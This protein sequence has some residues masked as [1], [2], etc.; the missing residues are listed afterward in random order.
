[1]SAEAPPPFRYRAPSKVHYMDEP[2]Q[3]KVGPEGTAWQGPEEGPAAGQVIKTFL[4]ERLSAHAI[5]RIF[6]SPTTVRKCEVSQYLPRVLKSPTT[7]RE[8]S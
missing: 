7:V 4:S 8:G 2:Y 6:K 1:M 3:T 5:P